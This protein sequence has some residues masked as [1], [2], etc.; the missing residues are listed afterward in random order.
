MPYG[1]VST[2]Y[3]VAANIQV[4]AANPN[5][6]LVEHAPARYYPHMIMR[7]ALAAP[8]PTIRDG[9]FELPD[10]PGLGIELDEDAVARYRV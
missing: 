10:G 3:A 6:P 2:L 9:V 1:Y 7:D 4:A 5:V 8:E